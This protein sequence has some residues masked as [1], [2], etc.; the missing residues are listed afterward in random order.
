[1]FGKEKIS[2][3]VEKLDFFIKV[4]RQDRSLKNVAY[5]LRTFDGATSATVPVF[6]VD[7]AEKWWDAHRQDFVTP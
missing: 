7:Y 1:M 2:K 4:A 5:A 3:K 6:D